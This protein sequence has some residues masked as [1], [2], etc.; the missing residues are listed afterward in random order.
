M[1]PMTLP[2]DLGTVWMRVAGQVWVNHL[3]VADVVAQAALHQQRVFLGLAHP[4]GVRPEKPAPAR[5]PVRKAATKPAAKPKAAAPRK[6]AIST[7]QPAPTRARRTPSKPP[8]MPEKL[9]KD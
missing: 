1:L 9:S 7:A 4:D 3:H 5:R 2:I 6:P 8:A